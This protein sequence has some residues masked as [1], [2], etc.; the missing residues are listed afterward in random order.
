MR[1][2]IPSDIASLSIQWSPDKSSVFGS[3][4]EDGLLN[5]WDYDTVCTFSQI[6]I[7]KVSPTFKLI[8]FIYACV[9]Q[10]GKKSE[11]APKTP[12]GLFFQHAGHR[13][14]RLNPNSLVC[15]SLLLSL[16]CN[17]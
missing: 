15:F 2:P 14:S 8:I 5:I 9:H 1:I 6:C 3:S 17:L 10:V 12:A 7:I 11:R 13:F 16:Q 4:A